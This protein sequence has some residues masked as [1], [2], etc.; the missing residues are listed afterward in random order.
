[1]GAACLTLA[2]VSCSNPQPGPAITTTEC[3]TDIDPLP[4]LAHPTARAAAKAYVDLAVADFRKTV[5]NRP[6][7]YGTTTGPGL[8]STFQPLTSTTTTDAAGS[9]TGGEGSG[10]GGEV[11]ASTGTL[12][13]R[14]V[15]ALREAVAAL[16][17]PAQALTGIVQSSIA[18]DELVVRGQIDQVQMYA[19][20]SRDSG[21]L[22]AVQSTDGWRIVALT[23][24]CTDTDAETSTG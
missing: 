17:G 15:D 9:S 5:A 22:W 4:V 1:M 3:R 16:P 12:A 7:Y 20:D 21:S 23:Y 19:A 13:R 2:L 24:P 11:S 6:P 14:A 18:D 10:S 8:T